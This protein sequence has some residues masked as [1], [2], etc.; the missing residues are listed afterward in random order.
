MFRPV[1]TRCVSLGNSSLRDRS[2]EFIEVS[3]TT[4]LEIIEKQTADPHH[5]EIQMPLLTFPFIAA[6]LIFFLTFCFLYL[7]LFI[8]NYLGSTTALLF[9]VITKQ[10]FYIFTI[11]M[12]FTATKLNQ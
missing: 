5:Y 6:I 4:E 3:G 11:S 9:I 7:H 10:I 2:W 1:P 8:Y 12:T